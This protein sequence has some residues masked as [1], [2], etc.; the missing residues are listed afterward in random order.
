M[1]RRHHPRG[2]KRGRP[3]GSTRRGGGHGSL[4][5]VPT[6]TSPAI[7]SGTTASPLTT[8]QEAGGSGSHEAA[9]GPSV[10]QNE[11]GKCAIAVEPAVC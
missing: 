4:Q 8:Q 6:P 9:S 7:G 3:R 2:T 11:E 1:R 5:R 10:P